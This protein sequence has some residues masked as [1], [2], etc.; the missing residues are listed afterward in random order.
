M[1]FHW[2]SWFLWIFID[3]HGFLWIFIAWISMDFLRVFIDFP[4]ITMMTILVPSSFASFSPGGSGPSWRPTDITRA[5]WPAKRGLGM[6]DMDGVNRNGTKV[7]QDYHGKVQQR[8]NKQIKIF[9]VPSSHP[10]FVF[11][12]GWCWNQVLQK[13]GYVSNLLTLVK[14]KIWMVWH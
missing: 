12:A 1:D 6:D 7:Y 4:G 5:T 3:C 8:Y 2:L 10:F 9:E 14:P 11:F 13:S